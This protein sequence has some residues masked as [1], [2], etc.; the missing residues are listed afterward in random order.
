MQSAM[1]EREEHGE[2]AENLMPKRIRQTTPHELLLDFLFPSVGWVV[3]DEFRKLVDVLESGVHR[4]VRVDVFDYSGRSAKRRY[5]YCFVGSYVDGAAAIRQRPWSDLR[6]IAS[7]GGAACAEPGQMEQEVFADRAMV[8][9]RHLWRT[10]PSSTLFFSDALKRAVD[11]AKLRELDF[12]HIADGDTQ[13]APNRL[14][15]RK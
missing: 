8:G 4:F 7:T 1:A 14:M 10:R 11:H 9:G 12:R 6:H 2:I 5:H 13:R 15:H 3:S